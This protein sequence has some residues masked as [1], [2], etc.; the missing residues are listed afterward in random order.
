MKVKIGILIIMLL[1]LSSKK[2]PTPLEG[3]I[4]VTGGRIWYR[5]LGSEPGIPLIV[6]HGGPGGSCCGL[7]KGFTLLA[8]ERPVILYDQL[9]S[10]NSDHPEDTTLWKLERFVEELALLR[11]ALN[12]KQY[13]ILGSSWGAAIAVEYLLTQD[14]SGVKSVIFSGPLLSTKQWI[15]DAKI[16]LSK[17]PKGLQDTINKY[18]SLGE[19]MTPSYIAATDSFYNRFL[20]RRG[21]PLT[22]TNPDC[23]NVPGFNEKIYNYMWGP[24][25]F[26]M[27]GTLRD[28]DR[29][30]DLHKLSQPVLFIVG[31]YDEVLTGTACHYKELTPHSEIRITKDAAHS[32]LGDQPEIYTETIRQFLKSVESE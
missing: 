25:E 23:I 19:F 17:L 10:G 2:D 28:F 13:H 30:D 5:V 12:L 6:I 15:S 20:T 14:T 27:R 26:T 7:I 21:W 16:L 31:E 22:N 11:K 3:Y 29:T 32:Q 24:S 1:T 9:E 8:D 4:E 18:E